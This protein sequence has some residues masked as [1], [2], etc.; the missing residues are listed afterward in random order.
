MQS[1]VG[2]SHELT[3]NTVLS[4]DYV[5]SLGRNLN[6]RPRLN[7]RIPGTTIRRVSVLLPGG[8]SPNANTARPALSRGK[9]EYNA[10]I[11][12]GRRR[13]S[14]GVDFTA[15]YTLSKGT[16]NIG[17]ASDE[18]NPA[19]IQDSSNPFDAPVQFGPNATTDARHRIT[20]SAVFE[21]PMGFRVSPFFLYRSA[22]PIVLFDGRDLN[23]D[24]DAV[25]IPGT[26]FAAD[27]FD[28]ETGAFTIKTIG[29][30]ATV[31]CGRG[32]AQSQMNLRVSKSFRLSG[33]TSVEAIA[34][35]FNLFNAVNPSNPTTVNRT[36]VVP[37]TGAQNPQ[38]LKPTTFSG[39][40]QRPEQRVGQIGFRFSF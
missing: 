9:S 25:D 36:V 2:W 10:L 26:A 34:E 22:L 23:L 21:L 37:T 5:S 18:N 40:F 27:S 7:Q 3:S 4:A 19:N 13:L 14:R 6:F 12:S 38:L 35:V 28:P 15:A 11:L 24:G 39:D 8:L 16:S 20:L 29:S 32:W 33:R 1:N 31:N 17:N 30:C